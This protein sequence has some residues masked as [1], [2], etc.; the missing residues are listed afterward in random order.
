MRWA[1]ETRCGGV[2]P[3]IDLPRKMSVVKHRCDG[4]TAIVQ[5]AGAIG[6]AHSQIFYGCR[7]RACGSSA[8]SRLVFA[9]APAEFS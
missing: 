2:A 4:L 3:L 6:C 7:R 8:D 1:V 9:G 5:L